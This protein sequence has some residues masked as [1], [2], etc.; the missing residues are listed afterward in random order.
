MSIVN[1]GFNME[2]E[3][4]SSLQIVS[5]FSLRAIITNLRFAMVNVNIAKLQ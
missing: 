3:P 5:L 2:R 4:D 1:L